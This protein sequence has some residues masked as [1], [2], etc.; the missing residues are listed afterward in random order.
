MSNSIVDSMSLENSLAIVESIN[1][2]WSEEN[3]LKPNEVSKTSS[4]SFK[5]KCNDCLQFSERTA[6]SIFNNP[7]ACGVCA[8]KII[9]KGF[10]D[11]L[12]HHPELADVW[13]Y[14]KNELGPES[15]SK[16]SGKKVYIKCRA[17]KQSNLRQI[18]NTINNINGCI[19]CSGKLV[20]P[21]VN[22]LASDSRLMEEWD[23]SNTV[24]PT[25]ITN[26]SWI[27]CKWICNKNKH[28]FLMDPGVRT[29]LGHNC[30]YCSNQRILKGFNDLAFKRPELLNEWDYEK[31]SKIGLD[32]TEV[33]AGS[34]KEAY[35]TCRGG[36]T[37]LLP[38]NQKYDWKRKRVRIC[39]DC[40]RDHQSYG[41]SEL[42]TFLS[43]DLGLKVVASDRSV[44][45]RSEIDCYLPD[46][47]IG[48]EFNGD[49]WH[50]TKVIYP[51]YQRTA[52]EYHSYNALRHDGE[53][54][55]Q[56]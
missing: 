43:E 27:E 47:K 53:S 4:E 20:V 16:T 7:M 34:Q 3:S 48:F 5:I 54:G 32:P 36:H 9:I 11:A 42:F 33:A 38:I 46:Y 28:S 29:N 52:E 17:C 44:L 39:T 30:Y 12:T 19:V 25:K 1:E 41:E 35:F 10:N 18:S 22:D 51:K 56:K 45:G 13:D 49:Y 23:P 14:E 26:R 21:G 40:L 55:E 8:G 15:Y 37:K 31:N 50:S 6:R 2:R 24:D